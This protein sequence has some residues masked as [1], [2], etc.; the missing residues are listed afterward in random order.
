M[1]SDRDKQVEDLVAAQ[2]ELFKVDEHRDRFL[3]LKI[4][5]RREKRVWEY[6]DELDE[7]SF[8]CWI[9]AESNSSNYAIAYSEH[10]HGQFGRPWGL[11]S[12][13][14]P[15]YG[16]DS[17]WCETLPEVWRKFGHRHL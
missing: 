7:N 6:G 1:N 15:Y 11:V 5:P 14:D 17:L 10:G 2:V 9:V 16:Q 4:E 3:E 12:F 8:P 13:D